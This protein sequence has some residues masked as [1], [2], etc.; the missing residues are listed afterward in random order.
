MNRERYR[1]RERKRYRESENK[2]TANETKTETEK[3]TERETEA[4]KEREKGWISGQSC[5]KYRYIKPNTIITGGIRQGA[6]YG[7]RERQRDRE[8]GGG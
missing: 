5:M 8:R 1:D 3:E 7:Q 2:E 6:I 4:E